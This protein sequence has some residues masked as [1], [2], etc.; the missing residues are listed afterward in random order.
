LHNALAEIHL[1]RNAPATNENEIS[2]NV[3]KICA[4]YSN[5]LKR[6]EGEKEKQK[7]KAKK[8]LLLIIK[9]QIK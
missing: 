7:R 9:T 3:D 2:P 5:G 4:E 1:R 8:K 6:Q